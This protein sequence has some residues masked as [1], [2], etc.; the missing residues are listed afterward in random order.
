M[1]ERLIAADGQPEERGERLGVELQTFRSLE[2]F[3]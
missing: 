2:A 1:S 3:P